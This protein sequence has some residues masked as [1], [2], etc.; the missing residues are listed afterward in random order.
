MCVCRWEVRRIVQDGNITALCRRHAAQGIECSAA[1]DGFL[2]ACV[3][4]LERTRRCEVQHACRECK[5]DAAEVVGTSAAQNADRLC[6]FET[7]A[8]GVA[9]RCVHICEKRGGGEVCRLPDCGHRFCEGA[10]IF[11]RLHKCA[12]S[13]FH[14]EE[15]GIRARG[16]LF[17]HDG[18]G[19]QRDAV[20]GRRHIAQGVEQLVRACERA[21]LCD[22]GEPAVLYDR[23]KFLLREVR[24]ESGD[25]FELVDGAARMPKAAPRHLRCFAAA[26]C[27]DGADDERGLV[28]DPARRVLVD[29][30]SRNRREVDTVAGCRHDLCECRR[31]GDTHA[32]QTDRHEKRGYLVVGNLARDIAA[33]PV[34]N[35]CVRERVTAFF[36][37]DDVVHIHRSAPDAEMGERMLCEVHAQQ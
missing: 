23:D 25:G 30:V 5:R 3:A 11:D 2:R 33:D 4:F 34:V 20:D 15:N 36:L 19:D 12:A 31:L 14:I 1:A 37:R 35:L 8:D 17:A 29:L 13:D 6:N 27:D 26:R 10:C 7:V 28:A 9:E 32:A 21:R 24:T 16:K 18:G 22:E